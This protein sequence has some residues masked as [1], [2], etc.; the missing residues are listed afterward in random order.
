MLVSIHLGCHPSRDK[1]PEESSL[2][3]VNKLIY[4]HKKCF[5]VYRRLV[6]FLEQSDPHDQSVECCRFFTYMSNVCHTVL[7][8][9]QI[10]FDDGLHI[11]VDCMKTFL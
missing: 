9:P 11:V 8:S 4:R 10:T 1:Y 5:P 3:D 2:C 7:L 6:K